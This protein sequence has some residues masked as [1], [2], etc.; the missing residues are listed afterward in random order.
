MTINI[1]DPDGAFHDYSKVFDSEPTLDWLQEK[2]GGYIETVTAPSGEA[3]M[4]I[5]EEGKLKH[6]P[7]NDRATDIFHDWFPGTSDVI[8]GSAIFL[9]KEHMLT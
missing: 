1:F 8:V 7:V 3:V 4:V 5:D 9:D 2:V 6:Y